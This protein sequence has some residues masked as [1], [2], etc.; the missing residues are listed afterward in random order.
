MTQWIVITVILCLLAWLVR[1]F[2]KATESQQVTE[3]RIDK[4]EHSL[5][6][7]E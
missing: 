3:T 4:I 6:S 7:K 1:L 5:W 2:F